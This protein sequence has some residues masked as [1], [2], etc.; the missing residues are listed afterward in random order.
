MDDSSLPVLLGGAILLL[1]AVIVILIGRERPGER[2]KSDGEIRPIGMPRPA[3]PPASSSP[4]ARKPATIQH[5]VIEGPAYVTDGD[6]LVIRKMQIRLF[7][8]DAPELNHPHGKNAKSA[9]IAICKGQ[10]IRAEVTDKDRFGR[11][12]AR[13]YLP[14]GR[15]LSAELVKAGLAIDWPKFSGGAYRALEIPDARKRMWLADARQKGRMDVWRKFEAG[16]AARA[17]GR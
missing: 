16:Q 4:W 12:V 13:C 2:S 3:S 1:I 15:D 14:D 11:L 8:I 17:Q 6:G 10:I 5:S 9:M 7:G